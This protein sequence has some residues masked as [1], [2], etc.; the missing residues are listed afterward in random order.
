MTSC[1]SCVNAQRCVQ[2]ERRFVCLCNEGYTG[3]YCDEPFNACSPVSCNDGQVCRLQRTGSTDLPQC[4][5]A[6]GFFG[7]NCQA[8]T[9]ASFKPSS[10]LIYQAS[11]IQ[12][13]AARDNE[14]SLIFSFRTTVPTVHFVGGENLFGKQQFS[15]NLRSGFLTILLAASTSTV[16][17]LPL[18]DGEW[19]TIWFNTSK[20]M[21]TIEIED[22][23]SGYIL[24]RKQ[25]PTKPLSIYTTRFGRI[26]EEGFTGCLRDVFV[27]RELV[28]LLSSERSVDIEAGC[29]RKEQCKSE[30]CQNGAT[31]ID[32]WDAFRCECVRPFLE[33]QC[34]NQ[35]REVTLGHDNTSSIVEFSIDGNDSKSIRQK[36]DIS[37]LFRTRNENG[38]LAFLGNRSDDEDSVGTFLS[39]EMVDG[40]TV[41]NG[42][43][44]GKRI[45]T[46][47]CE[48]QVND[49]KVH[50]LEIQRSDNDL[51]VKIDGKQEATL[52]FKHP[53]EH[54]LLADSLV[55]G[56][57]TSIKQAAFS[58]PTQTYFKGTLQDVRINGKSVILAD[59][60]PPF[61]LETFGQ[62]QIDQNILE[63]TVSDDLCALMKPCS[64]GKCFNTFN[65]FEC[66]CDAGW[67]GEKCDKK[68]FCV[69]KPCPMGSTCENSHGGYVCT[70]TAS[71]YP[72]SVVKY[73]LKLPETISPPKSNSSFTIQVRTRSKTGQIF[74]LVILFIFLFQIKKF[75][76]AK[77]CR[78]SVRYPH[79][80]RARRGLQ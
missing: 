62:K 6:P 13:P 49:N 16:N 18:A 69:D 77:F 37:F 4:A 48:T 74:K 72:T 51:R 63:G 58:T 53:F 30:T 76:L 34:V 65:D 50:L 66:Q 39:V 12:K 19:Y 45:L 9:T 25:L 8:A 70:S 64:Q 71:F 55:L 32:L 36:T 23:A 80:I 57:R 75:V 47:R 38:V 31:C 60:P 79:R 14:Y 56:D 42:R 59:D 29:N 54:P 41:V 67:I 27:D 52:Q 68:D 24:T 5:C 1:D 17:D 43:L 11:A 46:G 7:V 35:V 78:L 21:I 20:S 28:D 33:P 22:T 44:G 10:I 3:A 2:I 15:L 26:N 61:A 73:S 40:R